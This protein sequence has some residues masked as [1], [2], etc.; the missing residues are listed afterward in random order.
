MYWWKTAAL[1]GHYVG[2]D[3]DGLA[4]Q[5]EKP[6]SGQAG[7]TAA[8]QRAVNWPVRIQPRPKQAPAEPW[9]VV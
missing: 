9:L 7:Q 5:A 3:A 4:S 6:D 1:A 2:M 8:E